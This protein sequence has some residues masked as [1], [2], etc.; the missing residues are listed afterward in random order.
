[1]KK[2]KNP[3]AKQQPTTR[4]SDHGG[5]GEQKERIL[6]NCKDFH[7][8]GFTSIFPSTEPENFVG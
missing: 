5:R 1:M 8:H 4:Y 7:M 3:E 2:K 6:G